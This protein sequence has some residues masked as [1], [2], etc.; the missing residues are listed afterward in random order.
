M[1]VTSGTWDLN[2]ALFFSLPPSPLFLSKKPDLD[3][4]SKSGKSPHWVWSLLSELGPCGLKRGGEATACFH[5]ISH[6]TGFVTAFERAEQ[7]KVF[8]NNRAKTYH[9]RI[10]SPGLKEIQEITVENEAP[11][12]NSED[13]VNR[14][15][16]CASPEFRSK[17]FITL[18][19]NIDLSYMTPNIC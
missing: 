9:Q 13:P 16:F 3:H 10:L 7:N 6:H 19:I 8:T 14:S 12:A 11:E 5:L 1:S 18:V 17:F 2:F 4:Q 15:A